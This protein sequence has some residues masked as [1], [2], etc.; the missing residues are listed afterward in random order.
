MKIMHLT[1]GGDVGGAKTQ[2][3]TVL[4]EL[5]KSNQV[6]LVC[7]MEG[8]FAQEARALGIHTLVV[9]G[10]DP[11]RM[12][13]QLLE[14]LR[15]GQYEILHCHGAK[16][17]LFGMLL[18]R[19][20]SIP[21]VSTVHSDPKLDY[22]GRPL[23]NMTYGAAN[24]ISMRHRDGWVAVSD[25]V[26]ELLIESGLDADGIQTIYNGILFP[27]KLEHLPRAEYLKGLGIDWAD[28][29]VIYGIAARLSPVKDV[30]TLIRAFASAVKTCPKI[31]LMVA[32]D[33]EQIPELE[34]LV[35][36][37][38]PQDTVRFIGWQTDMNSFYHCLDVNM[39]SSISEAFPYS[40]IE[41]GRMG[42][43]TIATSVGGVPK[44]ILNEK[45]GFLVSAGDWEAMARCMVRL[46]QE[47]AL[48]TEMGQALR[49]KVRREFSSQVM[50]ENQLSFYNK[51]IC[52]YR[53]KKQGRY[54]AVICGAYGKGNVG[55]DAILLT[56]IRQLRQRDEYLP[57]CVMTRKPKET[58]RMTGVSATPIFNIFQA[59]KWMKKS[60]LYISGGGTLIQNATSTRSLMYYLFSMHQAKKRGCRVM[61]YGCGAG[62]VYGGNHQKL[63]A[64]VLNRNVD[65]IALRDPESERTLR[66]FGVTEP[67][68]SVTADPAL[69]MHGDLKGADRYLKDNGIECGTRFCL[70]VL[71][72]WRDA[73]ERLESVRAAAER[74]WRE[75][76]LMP[77]FLCFE[78]VQDE[79]ITRKAASMLGVPYRIL[80]KN[81][82][83][84][85]LCGVIARAE[86]VIAMRLHAL[87][88]AFSQNTKMV[89]I[90]YDPKVS[91]F[92]DY[93]G[94]ENWAQLSELN[95]DN[96]CQK[97]DRAM[98]DQGVPSN[99][100]KIKGLAEENGTIAWEMMQETH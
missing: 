83:C 12:R 38:C 65:R 77:V 34:T 55:D 18:R 68:I 66:R 37:T 15:Q 32:G 86:L 6:T 61:M 84:R 53:R 94:C 22:L 24:R 35:R 75:Y 63:V 27:E 71:R 60:T 69:N 97:V 93:A 88:F 13:N 64:R 42:C 85:Q 67:R 54:G 95:P 41:G 78:P 39:L 72:P 90:S 26:K 99:V 11:L 81:T 31:R 100:E 62:P 96:L 19:K 59:A 10:R 33:G 1:S 45:T 23:A 30:N 44:V 46:A 87:I 16:A 70:F 20:L 29:C 79:Q 43:A 51:I 40:I 52:R 5:G 57:I 80:S 21:V 76:G 25:S 17:N 73:C 92:M 91:G 3:L 82:D 36:Q 47:P 58:A 9:T 49:E 50:A 7:F 2:V 56:I 48:R 89:G 98:T 28:D 8:A 4:Q 74:C 14:L